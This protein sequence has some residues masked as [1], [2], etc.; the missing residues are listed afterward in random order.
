MRESIDC[1][2]H[3]CKDNTYHKDLFEVYPE[4]NDKTRCLYSKQWTLMESFLRCNA[5]R[6]SLLMKSVTAVELK[7]KELFVQNVNISFF[8]FYYYRIYQNFLSSTIRTMLGVVFSSIF[9]V[10]YIA[11]SCN[12]LK[13]YDVTKYG[14]SAGKKDN[15]AVSDTSSLYKIY[16]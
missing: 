14:A 2:T 15:Q 6:T 11:N 1:I 4:I 13:I 3:L 5:L 9:L 16:V 8:G 7:N 10:V 12:C